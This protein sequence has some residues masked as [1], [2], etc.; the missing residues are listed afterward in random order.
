MLCLNS[1][2]FIRNL[3]RCG[4]FNNWLIHATG[5]M[6]WI[7]F[8]EAG[9]SEDCFYFTKNT[10]I[11]INCS[12]D[13]TSDY[14]EFQIS[15]NNNDQFYLPITK[16]ML[17]IYQIKHNISFFYQILLLI[18]NY[19]THSICI[20]IFCIWWYCFVVDFFLPC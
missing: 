18:Y 4:F 17:S 16:I 15:C 12:F 20:Q 11:V 2:W 10:D 13:I 5:K 7:R 19:L 8:E 3:I 14:Y 9:F 6:I 1:W